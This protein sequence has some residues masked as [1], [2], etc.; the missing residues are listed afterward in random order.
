LDFFG[1][2]LRTV[3]EN[4][5]F[6]KNLTA[7]PREFGIRKLS[8]LL[9]KAHQ[10]S[11]RELNNYSQKK[12]E[13]WTQIFISIGIAS[14]GIELHSRNTSLYWLFV[15]T[16]FVNEINSMELSVVYRIDANLGRSCFLIFPWR[17]HSS[18][19]Q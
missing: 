18:F 19:A 13:D 17:G 4:G 14:S 6:L 11:C 8:P 15:T 1:E 12:P 2:S 7:A 10:A 16:W 5:A 9:Q 3:S